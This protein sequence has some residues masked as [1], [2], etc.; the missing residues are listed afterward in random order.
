M[1]STSSPIPVSG[2]PMKNMI[3]PSSGMQILSALV[4]FIG[5][6]LLSHCLSRRIS[7]EHIN[8]FR[9][10]RQLSWHR[11]CIVL[12][13]VDS[14]LFLFTSGVVIFG[15]GLELD[16]LVCNLGVYICIVFYA[17]SKVL[18]Y[19]FLMERVYIVWSPLA[20][21][22][23]FETPIYLLC[24]FF[25]CLFAAVFVIVII[26]RVA[27]F[28][29]DGACVIGLKRA[30]SIT[31]LSYDLFIN[32]FLTSLFLWPLLRTHF[33]SHAI[34]KVAR[35]TAFAAVVAL[36][37]SAVNLVIV[38]IMRGK[39]L[40]WVCLG[41][42][43]TDIII[44]ALVIFW[45][46]SAA[47]T[48]SNS[49]AGT[50][51]YTRN[52]NNFKQ[53]PS[54][55]ASAYRYHSRSGSGNEDRVSL[56]PLN[57]FNGSRSTSGL[58]FEGLDSQGVAVKSERRRSIRWPLSA[59]PTFWQRKSGDEKRVEVQFTRERVVESQGIEPP[60]TSNVSREIVVQDYHD[61]DHEK[62]DPRPGS[63]LDGSCTQ[64]SEETC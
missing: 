28:R 31:L 17:S 14:W 54:W 16:F 19:C 55:P 12:L 47:S 11:F 38:A 7:T 60:C 30:S 53:T 27:Y 61:L 41:S 52:I 25:L 49:C 43:G 62:S 50:P 57:G 8:S 24:F 64:F 3:F 59:L 4:H 21:K 13:F 26:G 58:A 56:P 48:N 22:K 39:Q 37:T 42:C 51:K 63:D 34:R 35:R 10:L 36:L 45:V 40:G 15:A 33:P 9:S 1:D 2:E 20:P 6:S 18:I 29:S 5:V 32:V 46:T 23:R 44:N